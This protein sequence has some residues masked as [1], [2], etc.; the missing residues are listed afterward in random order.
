[1]VRVQAQLTEEQH[2][3]LRPWAR[4]VGVSLSEA[5]RRCVAERL[6]RDEA[7]PSREERVRAALAVAG[8]RDPEGRL[9]VAEK[10]DRYPAEAH[11]P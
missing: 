11:H 2:R 10:H 7:G 9:R 3:G 6:A 4:Q 8:S 5:V 1:M